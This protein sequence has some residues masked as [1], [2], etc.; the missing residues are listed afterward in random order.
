MHLDLFTFPNYCHSRKY[1]SNALSI[2]VQNMTA[3]AATCIYNTNSESLIHTYSHGKK[4]FIF[5]MQS[6]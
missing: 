2:F 5:N 3:A 1:N 4:K 6:G